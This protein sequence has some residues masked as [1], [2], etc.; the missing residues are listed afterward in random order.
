MAFVTQWVGFAEKL[1]TDGF[2]RGIGFGAFERAEISLAFGVFDSSGSLRFGGL[3]GFGIGF[4]YFLFG[5]S[6]LRSSTTLFA[7]ALHNA[8][9]FR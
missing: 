1:V 4:G 7:I 5:G 6:R 9:G 2:Q 8:G 3:R